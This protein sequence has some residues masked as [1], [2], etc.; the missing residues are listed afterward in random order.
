MSI[1]RELKEN[2]YGAKVIDVAELGYVH[3]AFSGVYRPGFKMKM[4]KVVGEEIQKLG[5]RKM[6]VDFME[7]SISMST[8]E[9]FQRPGYFEDA[10]ISTDTRIAFAFHPEKTKMDTSFAEDI[11]VNRGWEVKFCFDLEEALAWL[12]ADTHGGGR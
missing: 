1:T 9:L 3:I 8:T 10:G 4:I 5:Y 6:L 2:H 11:F 12:L 7:G